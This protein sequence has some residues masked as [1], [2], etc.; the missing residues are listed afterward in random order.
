MSASSCFPLNRK[1]T[2]LWLVT[3]LAQPM[4]SVSFS[5]PLFAQSTPEETKIY[6]ATYLN[7]QAQ[8]Q[9]SQGQLQEALQTYNQALALF[10]SVG[11][12]GGEAQTLTYL[13][14]LYHYHL[15]QFDRALEAYQPA[16]ELWR[17]IGDRNWEWATLADLGQVYVDLERY[18]EGLQAFQQSLALTRSLKDRDGERRRLDDI[19]RVYFRIGQS[20]QAVEIYQQALALHFAE[21]SYVDAAGTLSNL[22]VLLVNLGEYARAL[23][24]YQ[25]ALDLYNTRL[26]AYQGAKATLLNNIAGLYFSLGQYD[27]A[28]N[29]SQQALKILNQI[30]EGRTPKIGSVAL[31]YDTISQY[32][33]PLE[34]RSN[35]A[36]RRETGDA[37]AEE[38]LA[39]RGQIATFSNLG[40]IYYSQGQYEQA[41]QFHQQALALSRQSGDQ[42]NQA[43]ALNNLGYVYDRLKQL[44]RALQFYQQALEIYRKVKDRAGEGVVLSNI[45]YVYDRQQQSQQAQQFYQ[46]A[47]TLHRAVSDRPSE[48]V[49]LN[50]L[51]QL[52]LKLGNYAGAVQTLTTAI[53]VLEALRPG[54]SDASKVAIFESQ[55]GTY[56]LLQQALI[57]QNQPEAA[58]EMAERGR[59]RAFVEFLAQKQGR[60]DTVKP[61]QVAAIK[62]I[63]Q[64]HQATLVEYSLVN[65]Q[66]LFIW[67]VKPTGEIGFRQVQAQ[68]LLTQDPGKPSPSLESVVSSGREA[69]GVRGLSFN[70]AAAVAVAPRLEPQSFKNEKLQQL[71]RLLIQP[72]ADLLPSDPTARVI[73]IPHQSLFLVPFTALQDA[74]GKYLIEQ[75]TPLIAPSIQVLALTQQQGQRNSGARSQR[76]T[77]LVGNPAMP[78]IRPNR[79]D[80]PVMLPA[81]PGAEKE[82]KEIATILGTEALIGNQATKAAVLARLPSARLIHLATHGLL[83]DFKRSGI[84]GAIALAPTATDDGFLSA[85]EILDLQLTADLVVLSACD[86]GRGRITGDGVIGLSRSLI[87][88]GV[89]SVIVSLWKV[90]DEPTAT[91][92]A[93][94]YRQLQR[95]PDKAQ[96]LRQAMLSTLQQYPDPRAWAAFTLI[97]EAD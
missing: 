85:S 7:Q 47:L 38:Q 26:S 75:H 39:E 48:S 20:N 6:E 65:A 29:F 14:N 52:Q 13:G 51:G 37:F 16:L 53:E 17:Q 10:R 2:A 18:D 67:V 61:I 15:G 22:G 56:G 21:S 36:V 78:Q 76:A 25:Q 44:D 23:E 95:Q 31:I 24:M 34:F 83:E 45:G 9:I 72:I 88:A 35:I 27:R 96:A 73:F 90:P 54:L 77:L 12:K 40:Q 43:I 92:M 68:A 62:Q 46:Q 1:V 33:Q 74:N 66:T 84:P 3:L 41:L 50:N 97:G 79:I 91:L 69:I 55:A 30:K 60:R 32:S 19:A 57:A 42:I 81:L 93:E 80:P 87:T 71:H 4:W 8:N 94:F 64:K 82:I 63:A 59:A 58:L 89:P 70:Q 11:A 49:T 28:L 86:T 5:L